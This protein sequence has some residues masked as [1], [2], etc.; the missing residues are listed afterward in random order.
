MVVLPG[1]QVSHCLLMTLKSTFPDV[2][3]VSGSQAKQA[4][5]PLAW[6]A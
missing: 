1:E 5:F 3:A 4:R 6:L 2:P